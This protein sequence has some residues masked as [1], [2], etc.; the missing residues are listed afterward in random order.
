[1]IAVFLILAI[2]RKDLVFFLLFV[3]MIFLGTIYQGME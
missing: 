1:M 2:V 3:G